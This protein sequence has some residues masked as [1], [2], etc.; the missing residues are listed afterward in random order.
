MNPYQGDAFKTIFLMPCSMAYG[1]AGIEKKWQAAWDKKQVF[2]SKE[3]KGKEKYYVLEMFPYPSGKL[4]MGHVRNYSI[5]DATARFKR[6]QGFN[7]LYPMGYDALGLPA[8]NAAIKHGKNPKEWT[9]SRIEEM[10]EQQK[11]L[12]FSYDWSKALATCD[13]GYY[14]WNQWFFLQLLEKGLAYKAKAKSNWCN[15]CGTVLANEQVE[16]GECWRCKNEVVEKEFDQWFLKI[17][18]Y[19]DELLK[20]LDKLQEWPQRVRTMQKNWI[21]KKQGYEQYYK[22]NGLDLS[23]PSFTTHH[24]TS[25]AEIFIAIAPEHPVALELVKDT[26]FEKRVLEFINKVKKNKTIQRFMPGTAKEGYFTGRYAKDFCSGRNLPIYVADFALMEFGTGIVKASA[27]DQRDFDFA[28]EHGIELVEVLFPNKVV[29][30]KKAGS[31]AEY[32][33]IHPGLDEVKMN[34]Y[35]YDGKYDEK[36]IGTASVETSGKTVKLEV[37]INHD[38]QKKPLQ[39]AS[40]VRQLTYTYFYEKGIEK[41]ILQNPDEF[42]LTPTEISSMGF[43]KNEENL[44]ELK[45]GNE[46]APYSYDGQG[47]MF[48][49]GQFSGM[50]VP[51]ARK[52][53]GPWMEKKGYAKKTVVYSL[54][55]WL[56]SRQRYWGTPIPIIYCEKC[57]AVPV[58]E[59]DLPVIL[60]ENAPFT[61][62]GNPLDKVPGFVNVSCPKCGGKARRETDTMDT[63]F[64]SSW[65][66]LRYC[67]PG[68]GKAMFDRKAV[69]YWMPVDQYIGGIEHAI[70]HLLY[71]RFFTKALRDI[72]ML[73]FDEPFTRLLTQG[74]VLKDGEVMSKSK[75]NVVDPG[76]II[77]KYG[78]D[79]ARTFVMSVSLP[80]KELEWNDKGAEATF[81]FLKKFFEFVQENKGKM[82]RGKVD[83][84]KLGSKD[85]LLLSKTHR[86]IA[87]VTEEMASFEFNFALNDIMRLFNAIQK[88]ES[89]DKNVKGFVARVLIQLLSPFAPHLCE[90]LWEFLGEKGFVSVNKWPEANEKM[91]DRKAEQV[92]EFVENIREDVRHIKELA[93]IERPSKVVFFT[94]PEWKWKAI[95]I[96][97]EACKERPDFGK[98]IKALLKNSEIRKH[99]KE[100][101]GFAKAMVQRIGLLREM[102]KIDEASALEEAKKGLEK[103][104]GCKFYVEKAEKSSHSK[105]RNALP[106]K[107]AIL[108]D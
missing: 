97:A 78:A 63:F 36:A 4:H 16:D 62:E 28:K 35:S 77:G 90:E 100:V 75:G 46:K 89:L 17:T 47:Y 85:R 1:F 10:K 43:K 49:S 14:H 74:M 27:H 79:T 68:E 6:M 30:K 59:K 26:P 94:S 61:G 91:I 72:G 29:G 23:L 13:S 106:L 95:P 88:A 37:K 45:K 83:S 24:H 60:P 71:A 56:I 76:E 66:F 54:R 9:L 57:G 2:R 51:E 34:D 7:V 107:P 40:V 69:G 15:S 105:A 65:Y 73:E 18:D 108:M 5:G 20:D 38:A 86:T 25:F 41:A 3:E 33:I 67:S 81:K 102:E 32:E 87:A 31:R 99:G 70:L 53:M 93:R 80:T 44:F 96:V 103:E 21:G 48:R 52:K 84:K 82:G 92:E 64:D 104:F 101:E 22:V 39:E 11:L 58:P 8:E 98:T 42:S 12:G 19:A 50:S 55:D